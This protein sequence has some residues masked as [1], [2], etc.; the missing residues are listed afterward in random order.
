MGFFSDQFRS[1]IEWKDPSPDVLIW[2]WDGG[3]DELKNASKLLINP[4]QAA[5]FV[6][7]GQV[8]A[9]HDYPGLFD[10]RTANIPFW[11]T[12][13]KFMQG[14]ASEHKANIY[15]VRLT[16]FLNQK[17]GTKA[18]IKYEDPKYKFPVGLRAFGNFSFKIVEPRKFFTE[19]TSTR[20]VFTVAEIRTIIVDRLMTPLTDLF[21]A[22]GYSYAEIDRKR[23]EL[24]EALRKRVADIFPPLGFELT[25][26]RIENTDF[27]EDTKRRINKIADQMAEAQAVRALGDIDGASMNNYT[28]VE[29]LKAIQAAAQNPGGMAGMGIGLGAGLGMGQGMAQAFQPMS[30]APSG[31]ATVPCSG[32]RSPMDANARFCP[33]CGKPNT[34]GKAA[35]VKCQALI[36]AGAKFCPECG[37]PQSAPACPG[38]QKPLAAGARFCPECGYKLA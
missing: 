18:P 23:V 37:A 11:T 22:S 7:Q 27:D 24:S 21:A 1:V 25:D 15:F 2:R 28:R 19:V 34:A 10:L 20:H 17:W 35:C 6:Y 31:G 29:Q 3:S 8:Q 4:G 9:I 36:T 16:E 32:C 5:I 26:F 30:G 14:F 38:C 12:I 13:T 33:N